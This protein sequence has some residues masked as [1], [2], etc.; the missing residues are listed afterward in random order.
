M[1]NMSHGIRTIDSYPFRMNGLVVQVLGKPM[2]WK[3]VLGSTGDGFGVLADEGNK[4]GIE[5]EVQIVCPVPEHR[6][7]ITSSRELE[8]LRIKKGRAALRRGSKADGAIIHNGEV[9]ALA[10]ADCPTVSL[11]DADSALPTAVAV[12]F[13]RESGVVGDILERALRFFSP[14]IRGRVVGTIS[15]G[16]QVENFQHRWDDPRHGKANK[17]MTERLVRD[18][19]EDSVSKDHS[20]GGINLQYIAAMKL[21]RAGLR[22][23]NI[24]VDKIDTYSD[25]RFWSHRASNEPG[26]K[27]GDVGR[28]LV[29]VSRLIPRRATL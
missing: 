28:N 1:S 5:G 20:L 21:I 23:E 16:I 27:K 12:H 15:L 19:G 4:L 17:E 9:Y 22:P 25:P 2:D 10:S 14:T 6:T 13:S 24:Y 11:H 7:R 18:Y 3:A 29:L 8:V 26:V